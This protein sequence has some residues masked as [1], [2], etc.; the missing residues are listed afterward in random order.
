MLYAFCSRPQAFK[1]VS[2]CLCR[3]PA[4]TRMLV[5]VHMLSASDNFYFIFSKCSAISFMGG[6]GGS[7]LKMKVIIGGRFMCCPSVLLKSAFV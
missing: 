6:G 5:H 4:I 1:N 7:S 2:K 3:G